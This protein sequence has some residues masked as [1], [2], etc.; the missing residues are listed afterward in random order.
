MKLFAL[1]P[2]IWAHSWLAC[3]DYAEKNGAVSDFI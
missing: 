2:S 1:I 3:T